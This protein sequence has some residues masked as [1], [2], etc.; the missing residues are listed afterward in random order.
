MATQVELEQRVADLE[1][2]IRE[3]QQ[4]E[5]PMGVFG[6]MDQLFPPESRRHMRAARKE[7]LLAFRAV[8]DKWIARL[9]EEPQ[10]PKREAIRVE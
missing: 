3:L 9:D 1:R 2:R 10:T 4:E 7:Q 6:L 8:I 5:G